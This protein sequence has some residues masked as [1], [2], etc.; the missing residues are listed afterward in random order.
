[1]HDRIRKSGPKKAKASEPPAEI[2]PIAQALYAFVTNIEALANSVPLLEAVMARTCT[3]ADRSFGDF[4]QKNGELVKQEGS[5]GFYKMDPVHMQKVR[6]L[7]ADCQKALSSSRIL[8]Q[9]FIV[10]LVSQYDFFLGKLLRSLFAIKPELLNASEKPL[11]YAQMVQFGSL[12]AAK[13]HIIEKEIETLLRKSHSEQFQWLESRFD[14]KLRQGLTIWP[15]FVELTERRNLLVHLDGVASS[16]YLNICSANHVQ[17]GVPPNIGDK[18]ETTID[19]FESSYQCV[20]EIGI[21]LA[22]V[23]WR[24]VSPGDIVDA[25]N[26]LN[27]IVYDLLHAERFDQAIM[28]GD[29]ALRTLK[30]HPSDIIR[31]MLVINTAQAYKWSRQEG[32]CQEILSENDWSACSDQFALAVS[33][34]NDH[35]ESAGA[36][37]RK[38]RKE[39]LSEM[40][41]REWPLFREFRKTDIFAASFRKLFGHAFA[42]TEQ[43]PCVEQAAPLEAGEKKDARTGG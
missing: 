41:Y 14:V 20:F 19:Y 28:V 43:T 15:V 4:L 6:K 11:S 25:D 39:E 30:K 12:E 36:T 31:R 21:K 23:L 42:E 9:S 13:E 27:I 8:R 32:K 34:L 18:L 38:I 37:M 35:F 1:M 5:K 29:F 16:Q 10:S 3:L 2:P 33:V 26:C 24:K 22:Q 7:R 40:N 17:F